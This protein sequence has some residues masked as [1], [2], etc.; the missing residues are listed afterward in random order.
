MLLD[1]ITIKYLASELD[2]SITGYTISACYSNN[3]KTIISFDSGLY[4]HLLHRPVEFNCLYL[5]DDIEKG[6]RT[7]DPDFQSILN[8]RINSVRQLGNDRVLEVSIQITK[9]MGQNT[10]GFLVMEL[11]GYH[12]NLILL[13]GDQKILQAR[14]YVS[15]H[16]SRYRQILNG[17]TYHLPPPLRGRDPCSITLSQFQE[18]ISSGQ[19]NIVHFLQQFCRLSEYNA[20]EVAVRAKFPPQLSID[21]L[22]E[23]D[24]KLL[25]KS[26]RTILSVIL[27]NEEDWSI[28][29]TE[30]GNVIFP[31][32]PRQEGVEII[33][34]SKDAFEIL[35]TFTGHE[36]LSHHEQKLLDQSRTRLDNLIKGLKYHIDSIRERI[37]EYRKWE[38]C[39]QKGDLL[40]SF[41]HLVQ[42]G[43]L[44]VQLPNLL[45]GGKITV[46]LKPRMDAFQNAE[47]YYKLARKYRRGFPLLRDRMENLKAK[48]DKLMCM[49]LDL[50]ERRVSPEETLRYLQS[51]F[52]SSGGIP[53]KVSRGPVLPYR[54]FVSSEGL[55]IWVGKSA[56]G[57]DEL[58]FKQAKLDDL[59]LHA[60]NIKGSHVIVRTSGKKEIP[61]NT[62]LEAAALAAHY[63]KSRYS[64]LVPVIYTKR[65]YVQRIKNAPPG[66]V[67]VLQYKVIMVKPSIPAKTDF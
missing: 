52:P 67:K 15:S 62:L 25:F 18:D 45:R 29:L 21:R 59:W 4:L 41:P 31:Y 20:I 33:Q 37:S 61:Q 47:H 58:T 28:G 10:E 46:E 50:S 6:E 12:N 34:R 13:D 64:G 60:E 7:R 19:Y 54:E 49:H 17:L 2:K 44:S 9:T 55:K 5:S 66:M 8:A 51:N 30:L 1:T 14:R 42:K 39:K 23:E 32:I 63:S 48:L 38:E 27:N 57:N 36:L 16:R 40:L 56:R 65:R 53:G 24:V 3:R 22:N 26:L 35:K 43:R 11:T